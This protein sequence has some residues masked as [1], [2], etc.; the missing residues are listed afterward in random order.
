MRI[1]TLIITAVLPTALVLAGCGP[2]S[3]TGG[4]TTRVTTTNSDG[5]T[6]HTEKRDA[7]FKIDTTKLAV[8]LSTNLK[9]DE[10][11]TYDLSISR[12]KDFKEDVELSTEGPDKLKVELKPK[13]VESSSNGQFQMVVTAAADAP[14]G[15][16]TIKLNAKP[17][18]GET[19]HT[20]IKFKVDA[21]K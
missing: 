6:E 15:E 9:Q 20:E 12:G 7:T 3:T 10:T 2:T 14:V 16:H 11:K 19:A 17:A 21:K 8:P 4:S 13:K 1:R 18:Q 5:K